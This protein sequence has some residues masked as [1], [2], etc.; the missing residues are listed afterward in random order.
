MKKYLLFLMIF[1]GL[2][3]SKVIKGDEKP[4]LIFIL[5]D[6]LGK[7][8]IGCYGAEN[9]KT[10]NIDK[11]ADAGIKFNK[12]YSMPQ[13][14]P[15]RIAL[16]TGQY[17]YKNGWIDH[18]DVPRWGHEARF[19][20]HINPSYAKELKK[21]GYKTCIAGKWQINDF[22]IEPQ[23][24]VNAGFD[25]YCM[26][27]GAEGGNDLNKTGSRYWDPYI[28]TKAGSKTYKG[29]FGPDIFSDFIIDFMT[30]NIKDPMCIYYPMVLTHTPFVHT[31][32]KPNAKTT[33]EKHMAMVEYT[34]YILG[35]I[36]DAIE[37]LKLSDN[38]YL[39][40]TTDNG[41]AV[42]VIGKRNGQ[43]I[44]GGKVH[45]T[46]NGINAPFIVK[47]PKNNKSLESE[48]LVDFTDIYP[49]FL[50]LAGVKIS[51]D[52]EIEGKSFGDVLT[53][54][55]ETGLRNWSLSM[56]CHPAQIDDKGNVRNFNVFRDR[57]F[58]DQ[59]YKIYVDT[60]KTIYRI[61]DME[62]DPFESTNLISAKGEIPAV[63]AKYEKI[64]ELLPNADNQPSYKKLGKSFY[65]IPV[66]KLN[67]MSEKDHLTKGNM[68]LP[69]TEAEYKLQWEDSN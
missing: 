53:Q 50:D 47:I 17:P 40:F 10:P 13:C 12:A 39:I 38:T 3:S 24:T 46:E 2:Y 23:A 25:E 33:I 21:V 26:W 65:D 5:V 11:L 49:T 52:V 67:S 31:P 64:L 44:R 69:A 51:E 18:F 35:N 58:R 60:S 14:T 22:R 27:T 7:E 45:L 56:G 28:H 68:S 59:Q 41:T 37:K 8:W 19:D 1:C 55:S 54:E 32:H 36:V 20:P 57:I 9:I 43:F 15:T 66:K 30:M 29:Q 34:D 63:K 6:D 42:K 62:K 4:N 61:Y 48:A 16:L